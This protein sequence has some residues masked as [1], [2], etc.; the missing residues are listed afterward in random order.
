[1]M[2]GGSA[3]IFNAD[4]HS[5]LEEWR[6]APKDA[7]FFDQA[8]AAARRA[9][10][11]AMTAW[12]EAASV[13]VLEAWHT[14]VEHPHGTSDKDH[15]KIARMVDALRGSARDG[16]GGASGGA[17]GSNAKL[18]AQAKGKQQV[19]PITVPNGAKA[20]DVLT[21][22]GENGKVFKIAV[23]SGKVEGDMFEWIVPQP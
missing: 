22:T 20:G 8:A 19:V 9:K 5:E 23:P 13:K 18:K 3:S 11:A 12:S 15:A 10:S 14:F 6:F 17:S 7:T 4:I 16:G 1:M 2:R 21:L